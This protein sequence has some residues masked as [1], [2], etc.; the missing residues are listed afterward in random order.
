[1]VVNP[2]YVLVPDKVNV[3]EPNLVKETDV[4][5]PS[6]TIPEKIVDVLLPPVCIIVV[7]DDELVILPVPAIDPTVSENPFKS[8]TPLM[9]RAL[10]SEI[11]LDVP[12][13]N[14]PSDTVVEP[15]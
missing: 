13:F 1:M 2:V 10:E 9:I 11:L 3:P 7:P 12:S 15:V 4:A 5:E 14:V 8:K 6:S